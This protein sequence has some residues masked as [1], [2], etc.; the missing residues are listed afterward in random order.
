MQLPARH[1]CTCVQDNV[2]KTWSY[3]HTSSAA[4]VEKD[5][6]DIRTLTATEVVDRFLL[7]FTIGYKGRSNVFCDAVKDSMIFVVVQHVGGLEGLI[8][9]MFHDVP[10]AKVSHCWHPRPQIFEW[11]RTVPH[12]CKFSRVSDG[13]E[14]P[15]KVFQILKFSK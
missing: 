14:G 8:F 2:Y 7:A 3:R 5:V 12:T 13:F 6:F 11:S 15:Q 1:S 9:A 4:E 10:I